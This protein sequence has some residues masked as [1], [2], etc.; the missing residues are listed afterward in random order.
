MSGRGPFEAAMFWVGALLAFVPVLIGL[1]IAA[2]IVWK[3]KKREAGGGRA[4]PPAA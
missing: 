3:R 2:Y 1:G 4:A